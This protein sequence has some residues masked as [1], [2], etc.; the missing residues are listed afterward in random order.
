MSE[1]L[2]AELEA[3][4]ERL[5]ALAAQVRELGANGV[6]DG[7]V[8]QLLSAQEVARRTGLPLD[9]VYQLGREG[10]A[11]AVRIGKRAVRFGLRGLAQWQRE[12][13]V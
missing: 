1:S 5:M 12:G 6:D 2:A 10:K 8:V 11:G 13:G 7:E 4:A 3:E 9:R